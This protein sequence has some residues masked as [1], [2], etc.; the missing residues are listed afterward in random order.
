MLIASRVARR[1]LQAGKIDAPWVKQVR[2][3]WG[4]RSKIPSLS[5]HHDGTAFLKGLVEFIDAL[6]EDI[7]FNKAFFTLTVKGEPRSTPQRLK[8]KVIQELRTIRE[9]F[10]EALYRIAYSVR[11]LDPTSYEYK[12]SNGHALAFYKE[13]DPKSPMRAFNQGTRERVVKA[14]GDADKVFRRM[15]A[16]ITKYMKDYAQPEVDF[17]Q[18]DLKFSVGKVSVVYMD[19]P[20]AK[21]SGGPLSTVPTREDGTRFPRPDE[22]VKQ[23]IV[24]KQ[25][26]EMKG[27]G[28]LWYGNLF[29]RCKSCGGENY[30]GA[31]FGV[32]AD[33]NIQSDHVQ[34]YSDPH[35]NLPSLIIHE[36]GHR[37][38]YRFMGEADRARFDSYFAGTGATPEAVLRV[39]A[40]YEGLMEDEHQAMLNQVGV[41]KKLDVLQHLVRLYFGTMQPEDQEVVRGWLQGVPATSTYG[42]TDSSEDFAEVFS[43]YVMGEDL[44]SDQVGRFKAFLGRTKR[45]ASHGNV[46]PPQALGSPR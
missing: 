38:Y 11:E 29:I 16:A 45:T 2:K 32:G 8:D 7:L 27:L 46:S 43:D 13:M 18:I 35:R 25:L 4:Q 31:H 22:Y 30:L 15:L 24:S 40:K 5:D 23:L 10:T 17:G 34:V 26:L 28:Y 6:S 3:T 33:Y 9:V 20:S 44:T 14:I 42:Q 41:V 39:I 12:M 19:F 36:L 21:V 1:Y 37:Y